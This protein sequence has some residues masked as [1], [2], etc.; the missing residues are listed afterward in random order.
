EAR[1]LRE[2]ML[3]GDH[4]DNGLLD[5]KGLVV[6]VDLPR[7]A[8]RE[9]PAVYVHGRE[10]LYQDERVEPDGLTERLRADHA[11]IVDF[12]E[13][14]RV[15]GRSPPDP[16]LITLLFDEAATWDRVVAVVEAAI[17]AGF[18]SPELAFRLPSDMRPPPRSRID[19]ELDRLAAS[20]TPDK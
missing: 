14:H 3:V 17:A 19:D 1:E 5:G 18:E 20:D 6:R 11:R 8:P 4:G 10:L 15:P 12:F 16:K 13:T 9:A 2:F 7:V